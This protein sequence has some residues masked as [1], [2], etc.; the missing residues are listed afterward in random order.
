MFK[1]IN[2]MGLIGF[3]GF[4]IQYGNKHLP[5]L[6]LFQNEQ[7][8]FLPVALDNIPD[9]KLAWCSTNGT[10]EGGSRIVKLLFF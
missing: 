1:V 10:L 8:W 6:I 2:A 3:S 9:W 4:E 5:L 7:F